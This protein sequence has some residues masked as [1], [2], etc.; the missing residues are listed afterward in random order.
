MAMTKRD[1]RRRPR[2]RVPVLE[3]DATHHLAVFT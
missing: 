2:V 1:K 3:S